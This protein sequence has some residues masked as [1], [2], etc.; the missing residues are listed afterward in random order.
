MGKLFETTS[1]NGMSL[2]NRF[3]RSA[4]WEG[5]ATTEGEVTSELTEMMISLAKGGVGL[6]ISGHAYVSKEGQASPR[7]LGAHKDELISGL[8]EMTSAVHENGGKI[9]MQLAH[10]G[11]FAETKLTG[12]PALAVS[13]SDNMPPEKIKTITR[14]DVDHIVQSYTSGAKRARKAGFD[15]IQIHSAHGYL[16]SQFLSPAFNRRHD[17]YGGSV[18]NRHKIHIMIYR[19]IRKALGED[20][21]VLIKMNCED[22][23]ENGITPDDS[24]YTA[25]CL[26]DAGFDAIE[27]SGGTVK[28][29]KLSPTR[30][31]INTGDK[32][33]Y[34]KNYAAEF[35]KEISAPLILVGGI[36]SFEVA[37]KIITGKIAD[38]ISMSRAFIREPDLISRWEKGDLRKAHCKSDNL[39]FAPGFEGK[40]IYC[41]TKEIETKKQKGSI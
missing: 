5:L 24:L 29:K 7:Q 3:V 30:T 36:K 6:I 40:G 27:L 15:G 18:D 26:A 8:K 33:A 35:K 41:V 37:D 10:A 19:S 16:L 22:F 14:K 17:E 23:I 1:I 4:T 31:G 25:K 28:S 21:P 9:I 32:E 2:K 38:Y 11:Q 39:C 12:L 20:Y 34:F 13:E